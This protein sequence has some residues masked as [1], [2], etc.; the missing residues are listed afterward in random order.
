MEL[1][2][3]N[4]MSTRLM[5]HLAHHLAVFLDAAEAH[6]RGDIPANDARRTECPRH[7]GILGV[8]DDKRFAARIGPDFSVIYDPS[9]FYHETLHPRWD[10]RKKYTL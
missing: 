1:A 7:V 8:G 6:S 10:I 5:N 9:I 3:I 2:D 4:M